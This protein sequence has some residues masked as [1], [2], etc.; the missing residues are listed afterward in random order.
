MRTFL[1]VF[2]GSYTDGTNA[3]EGKRDYR[4]FAGVYLMG[5]ILTGVGW[6]KGTVSSITG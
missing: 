2:V 4:F 6:A 5:R 1:E 3:S